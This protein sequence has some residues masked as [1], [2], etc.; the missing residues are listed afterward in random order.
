MENS[1]LIQ[2]AIEYAQKN[3]NATNM[4]VQNVAE[5]AGFSIDYF[6]R[7]F[8]AHTGFSVMS[9]VNYM[10]IKQA[11]LLL[12]NS[13]KSILDIALE[14][15]YDSHEGFIKAFK[16]I[17]GITPSE[18]R[19]QNRAK[20]LSWGELTD[21]SCAARFLH[22]NPDFQL[23]DSDVVIDY[24]LEK[25]WKRYGYFCN[26]IKCMGLQIAAPSDDLARGFIG[27]GDDRNGGIWLE[28]VTDDFS[29]LTAWI[30]RFPYTMDFYT[31]TSPEIVLKNLKLEGIHSE[32]TATP[33]SF[34]FGGPL[35]YDLPNNII[36]RELSYS[37]K[38]CILKWASGK[39]NGYVQ[40]LLNEKHYLDPTVLEYGVFKENELIA[41]AGC[42]IDEVHGFCLNDC[43]N[44]RFADG[45]ATDELYYNIF[46][47]VI[48]DLL[49]KGI[50]PFDNLQ[51]GT[52]IE[53]HGGFT[54]EDVGF[55]T[56]NWR[57]DIMK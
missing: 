6:N 44:I 8:L 57:Y 31:N 15:G 29:L 28:L 50:L 56:V 20:I 25:D 19:K 30:K 22:E 18:Y 13:E 7:I 52:Y 32:I 2:N 5:H 46:V 39:T 35:K 16:K 26:T 10:R 36:I 54:A 51:H 37:D 17:Y 14:I 21:S 34:Y 48:N 1:E 33:H 12:R 41:I 11:V 42:G 4:S 27:I 24:L 38:D 9:Y 49:A 43:C 53:S 55:T 40:H 45:K 23:I 3:F 47:F